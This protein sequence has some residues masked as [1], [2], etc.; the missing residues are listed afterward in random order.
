MGEQ[1]I[2]VIEATGKWNIIGFE[3]EQEIQGELNYSVKGAILKLFPKDRYDKTQGM[4]FDM[5]TGKTNSGDFSLL[6]C[7]VLINGIHHGTN[8][9]EIIVGTVIEGHRYDRLDDIKFT[10]AWISHDILERNRWIFDYNALKT[11]YKMTKNA[12]TCNYIKPKPIPFYSDSVKQFNIEYDPNIEDSPGFSFSI[13]QT[14]KIKLKYSEPQNYMDIYKDIKKIMQ[15]FSF[16]LQKNCIV[17]KFLCTNPSILMTPSFPILQRIKIH[18]PSRYT[19][20]HYLIQ[21]NREPLFHFN[22][23]SRDLEE[24]YQKWSELYALCELE[25]NFYLYSFLV[26][27]KM[28]DVKFVENYD[29]IAQFLDLVYGLES[30]H[31]KIEGNSYMPKVEYAENVLPSLIQALPPDLK[32]SHRDSLKSRLSYGYEFSLRKRISDLI[33]LL[34][35]QELNILGIG[36]PKEKREFVNKIVDLRNDLVHGNFLLND[37]SF[38]ELID[39][40]RISRKLFLSCIRFKLGISSLI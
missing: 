17:Y 30:F 5:I 8:Y 29:L 31:R 23:I 40:F 27:F 24:I 22:I 32:S 3:K 21:E 18:L 6:F 10:E 39:N 7:S 26:S 36:K 28:K 25:I 38:D 12:Y 33:D 15:F 11:D 34:P 1:K 2:K 37:N 19:Y 35:P 4:S 9:L 20:K 16:I 13:Q 14:H